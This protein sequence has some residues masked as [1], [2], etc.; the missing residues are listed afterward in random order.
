[1]NYMKFLWGQAGAPLDCISRDPTKTVNNFLATH[2]SNGLI[3]AVALKRPVHQHDNQRVA[4]ELCSFVA[5]TSAANFVREGIDNG[6]GV[7]TALEIST[8][9]WRSYK[10]TQ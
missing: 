7:M 6:R 9:A 2:E 10:V 4:Y 3:H 8:M 5:G 1:M